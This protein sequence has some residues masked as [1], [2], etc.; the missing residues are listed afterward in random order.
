MFAGDAVRYGI[1]TA[2]WGAIGLW[3]DTGKADQDCVRWCREL[4]ECWQ[5]VVRE[6]VD[7]G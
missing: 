7:L 2:V 6:V 5:R 3:V 4:Q 1:W